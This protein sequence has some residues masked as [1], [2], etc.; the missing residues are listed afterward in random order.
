M[1]AARCDGL[2]G[3]RNLTVSRTAPILALGFSVDWIGP[4]SDDRSSRND[5]GKAVAIRRLRARSGQKRKCPSDARSPCRR[6]CERSSACR[7]Q[8]PVSMRGGSSK[9]DEN[10]PDWYAACMMAEHAGE[11][12]A[13]QFTSVELT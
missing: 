13:Q 1:T 7:E 2:T 8:P 3:L 11:E 5:E 4:A 10:W 9:P 12:L 6:S